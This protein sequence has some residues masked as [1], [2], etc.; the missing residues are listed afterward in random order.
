M[1][2]KCLLGL[3]V[4]LLCATF[5]I[6]N[7][8]ENPPNGDSSNANG[9]IAFNEMLTG[10]LP[11]GYLSD[12]NPDVDYWRFS[13]TNAIQYTFT[14]V[15][16]NTLVNSLY[17]GLDIEN[18]VGSIL[19]SE[20]ASVPNQTVVLN[21]TCGSTGTYYLVVWEATAYQNGTAYYEVTCAQGSGV[22][23]WSLY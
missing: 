2:K 12:P 3:F 4:V 13:G 16:K 5:A 6:A 11:G 15:A 8:T 23:D 10:G 7:Q 20:T 22:E 14:G 17:I 19:K 1:L 18:S 9:P 21:W